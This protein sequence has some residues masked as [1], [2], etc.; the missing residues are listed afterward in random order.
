M[1]KERRQELITVIVSKHRRQIRPHTSIPPSDHSCVKQESPR[2]TPF[3]AAFPSPFPA[4]YAPDSPFPLGPFLRKQESLSHGRQR[5]LSERRCRLLK[6]DSCLRRNGLVGDGELC[7]DLAL[8]PEGYRPG[9]SC[10]RRN[11]LRGNGSVCA[12]FGDC[13]YTTL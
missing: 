7:A 4:K 9:D 6:I 1:A 3:P 5:R 13:A 8:L 12:Y 2:A 10:F 11:G